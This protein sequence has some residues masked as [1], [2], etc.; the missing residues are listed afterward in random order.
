LRTV[1]SVPAAAVVERGQLQQVFVVESGSAR[2]R[3]VTLGQRGQS[4][5]EVLSGLSQG[6]K[7]VAPVPAGLAD[8]AAVEVRQ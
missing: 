5:A 4:S 6:E 3:L 7:V 2:V 1:L 8:G